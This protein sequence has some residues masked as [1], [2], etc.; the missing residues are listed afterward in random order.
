MEINRF[1]GVFAAAPTPFCFDGT[2]DIDAVNKQMEY[3]IA[4][5]ISGV[6][7]LSSTGEYFAMTMSQRLR[8]VD[9][10]VRTVAGRIPVL[11]MVSDACL[12]T[13]LDNIHAMTDHGADAVV[14]T[15]PYYYRYSQN[16]LEQFFTRAAEE[17]S[18]PL[19]LYNQPSRL[20]SELSEELV[21]CLSEHPNIIGLKDTS[22]DSAR[23]HRM[24]TSFSKR[25]DFIY[26]A[27]SESLAAQAALLGANYVYALA[28]VEP[29]LFVGMQEMA[30][31]GDTENLLGS[32][33]K[34]DK[35]CGLFR[36]VAGGSA[37]S[38]TNFASS[39]KVALELKGLGSA[40]T[41]QLGHLPSQGEYNAIRNILSQID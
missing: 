35:L 29:Q 10:V 7:A 32:Q 1:K 18:V 9:A 16:E 14:L 37:E 8:M 3:Y 6:F 31:A 5:G 17:S 24:S 38:F 20:P 4:G 13:V 28:C 27:G 33:H 39:I 22:S 34:V 25:E 15:A 19:I 2:V 30:R 26:F 11:A 23:L 21:F 36:A 40:Y 12:N 41:A